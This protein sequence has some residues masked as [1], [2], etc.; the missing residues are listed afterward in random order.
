[1]KE[2]VRLVRQ[3]LFVKVLILALSIITVVFILVYGLMTEKYLM[4]ILCVIGMFVVWFL[5]DR[6]LDMFQ[7]IPPRP[8]RINN[9]PTK[10]N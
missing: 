6:L 10:N 9:E 8:R 2:Y 7:P 5:L 3:W 4:T 1:M